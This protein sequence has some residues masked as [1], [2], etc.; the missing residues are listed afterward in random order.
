MKGF[1]FVFGFL[2]SLNTQAAYFCS[3]AVHHISISSGGAFWLGI[4]NNQVLNVCN[5]K[6]EYCKAWLS[7][8]TTARATGKGL[9]L[10]YN[11]SGSCPV[12]SAW[13]E[14]PHP[15]FDLQLMK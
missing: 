10:A 2:F 3:G 15:I 5:V 6:D 1:I 12:G 11:G 9:M 7:L 4:G 14:P 13:G 8:A